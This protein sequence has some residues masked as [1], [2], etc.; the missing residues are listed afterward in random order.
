MDMIISGQIRG[1]HS[2]MKQWFD[3]IKNARKDSVF[4]FCGVTHKRTPYKIF[5]YYFL[6]NYI[7]VGD[8][9]L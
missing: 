4:R 6:N 5:G 9:F 1:N 3:G 8:Y 2:I 7:L